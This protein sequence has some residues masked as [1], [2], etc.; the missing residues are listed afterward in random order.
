MIFQQE[1]LC[2]YWFWAR[3]KL[4]Q[5]KREIRDRTGEKTLAWIDVVISWGQKMRRKKLE[6]RLDLSVGSQ[7]DNVSLDVSRVRQ[8]ISD[9]IDSIQIRE[10]WNEAGKVAG[11]CSGPGSL[12]GLVSERQSDPVAHTRA[13]EV[14]SNRDQ[15]S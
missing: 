1:K 12:M 5:N 6:S 4:K 2:S 15:P 13:Y 7:L 8:E 3:K 14:W 11:W 9:L 10:A